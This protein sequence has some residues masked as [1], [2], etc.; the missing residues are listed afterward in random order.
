MPHWKHKPWPY[1]DPASPARSWKEEGRF[2][3]KNRGSSMKAG[4]AE[5][6]TGGQAAYINLNE[7]LKSYLAR[8]V[9]FK[10]TFCSPKPLY[11]LQIQAKLKQG[12]VA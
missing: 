1:K 11:I 9:L 10:L 12:E 7:A 4:A 8:S 2:R 6:L 3:E 5:V